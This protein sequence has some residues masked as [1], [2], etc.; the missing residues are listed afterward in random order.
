MDILSIVKKIVW[1]FFQPES[2]V[3]ITLRTQYHRFTSTKFF[4]KCKIQQSEKSYFTWLQFQK[5]Q[6]NRK[7][8]SLKSNHVISFFLPLNLLDFE[9]CINTI[10]SIQSQSLPDWE[11]IVFSPN[12]LPAECLLNQLMASDQRIKYYIEKKTD[13]NRFLELSKGDYFIC[14]SFGD[15]FEENLISE[16]IQ[17]VNSHLSSEIIYTDVDIKT[18]KQTKPHAFFKPEKYSPELHLS[19][20][21]L[22]SALVEKNSA[23]DQIDKV[24]PGYD[25]LLQ[26]WELM[27]LLCEKHSEISHI[28]LVLVHQYRPMVENRNQEKSLMEAHFQRIGNPHLLQIIQGNEIHLSWE[29]S[30]PSVSIVIP[31]KNHYLILKK[32]IDSLFAQT[33]YKDFEVIIVDNNSK[34]DE[35]LSYYTK[36][37]KEYP[38]QIIPFNEDF[39]YSKAINL[40]AS[41]SQ[42]EILLFLNNDMEIISPNWLNELVQ[43]VMV[44]EIGIVGGKLLYGNNTI[45]HA[46]MIIGLQ[47]FVGHLYLHAPDHYFGLLGSVDWYR[48]VSAITGAC[49][50]VRRSVFNELGGYDEKFRLVFNDVDFCLRAIKRGYR[51]L[52]TPFAE[53]KHFEGKSRGFTTPRQDLLR[54]FDVL[55]E[56]ISKE[57]P[58]FSLNLTYTTIPMCQ[59]GDNE[60]N[61]RLEQITQ[62][63]KYIQG[64]DKFSQ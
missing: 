52:Y 10:E 36:I 63:K 1:T 5:R 26:E 40:G 37:T 61:K 44:P 50:M 48:N 33:I 4:I 8:E 56:W 7:T 60:I 39:N 53:I 23:L 21:Y 16:S 38:V 62:R 17:K 57:D 55:G 51:N 22:S 20:N 9:S 47:G 35:L 11:L 29:L 19:V 28:P 58:Y 6:R 30:E 15:T 27:F 14:C 45:Q 25:F 41:V 13:L 54:G 3:E 64:S 34:E 32:L 31:S 49:Q 59:F 24:D 12:S 46:G 43:W 2:N 42:S 18:N